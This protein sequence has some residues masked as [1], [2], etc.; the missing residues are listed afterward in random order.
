MEI[1][2]LII[3]LMLGGSAAA[4]I[5]CC[6]QINQIRSYESKIQRLME[7]INNK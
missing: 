3:G 7:K 6:M 2:M 5:L 4:V 1:A